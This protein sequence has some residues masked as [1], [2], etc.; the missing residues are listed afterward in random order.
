MP[1]AESL[2]EI[3]ERHALNAEMG[4]VGEQ[5]RREAMTMGRKRVFDLSGVRPATRDLVASILLDAHPNADTLATFGIRTKEHF[6]AIY[7]PVREQQIT[8]E[9]LDAAMGNGAKITELVRAAEANPHKDIEF[10]TSWDIMFAKY[11][12][13][14][15]IPENRP[16]PKARD[17][18]PER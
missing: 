14:R 16:K 12:D 3:I 5:L 18:E 1:L 4:A 6:D 17:L 9:Q 13:K 11:G 10:V 8:P 15:P 7:G 2:D